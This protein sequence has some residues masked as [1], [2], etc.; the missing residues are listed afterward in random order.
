MWGTNISCMDAHW[1][2]ARIYVIYAKNQKVGYTM[3]EREADAICAQHMHLQWDVSRNLTLMK[4]LEP[5]TLG[6]T[7]T[8]TQHQ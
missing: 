7:P 3:T 8:E 1:V 5:L 6:T 4:H 2:G